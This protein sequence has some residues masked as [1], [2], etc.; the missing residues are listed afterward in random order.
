MTAVVLAWCGLATTT[1]ASESTTY[2]F[3][4]SFAQ[5]EIQNTRESTSYRFLES[6][7]EGSDFTL[8]E[9]PSNNEGSSESGDG[10]STTGNG[11][12]GGHRGHGTLAQQPQEVGANSSE[13]TQQSTHS[14]AP[15]APPTIVTAQK[16]PQLPADV[17]P[18]S[19]RITTYSIGA[20][21]TSGHTYSDYG[22]R[23]DDN[24][25]TV[26]PS[27]DGQSFDIRMS[28]EATVSIVSIAVVAAIV[29]MLVWM[30]SLT[31]L[32]IFSTG[33]VLTWG[34]F[35][36]DK[37]HNKSGRRKK[38]HILTCFV[39][40]TL[41]SS[42]F[43]S[44]VSSVF[45]AT[46]APLRHAYSGRLLD[47][48]SIAITTD[49]TFRFSY[50]KSADSQAG[51]VTGTGAIN[52]SATNYGGWYETQ[53]VTPNSQGYVLLELGNST[54]LPAMDSF[55]VSTLTSLYLQVEVKTSSAADT[56]YE[57]L[58][59]NASSS[60]IDRSS[61]LSV[62]LAL[63]ADMLDQRDVGTGS[64]SIPVLQAGGVLSKAAIAGGTNSGSFVIDA[65]ESE[66][67]S[68]ILQ[69][70]TSLT[71]RLTFD[72]TNDR[73]SF[74]KGISVHGALSGSTLRI[75][76][77][78]DI[79]GSLASSGSVTTR[80][81]LSGAIVRSFGLTDCDSA[82]TSKLLWDTT[83]GKFSCGYDT[84]QP[85]SGTGALQ[86]T[87]DTRYVKQQ[88]GTMTG[89]LVINLSS[90]TTGL[91][92]KQALSGSI[93]HA[94]GQL[95]SSGSLVV[96]GATTLKST[97]NVTGNT[98]MDGTSTFNGTLTFGDALTDA[99]TIYAAT[100]TFQND[101]NFALSGGVNGLSFDTSTLSIDAQNDRVGI[102]T[103]APDATLEIAGTMSGQSL[104]VGGGTA[105]TKI[106]ST[107]ATLDF[108]L[109]LSTTCS[110]LTMT[111]TGAETGD[112]A[113]VTVDS[114]IA[115]VN[116]LFNAWVS[117]ANTVSVRYCAIGASINVSS[118]TYRV[119]VFKH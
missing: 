37:L 96:N 78:A 35:K 86:T 83:T 115:P 47:S 29:V 48:N 51:D 71:R 8:I 17:H 104:V 53:T 118:G 18:R 77:N 36:S 1:H 52:T 4:E 102:G 23:V 42:S 32:S 24:I 62:P 58:D 39:L 14:A 2:K 10:A 88:G 79:W 66:S 41:V 20:Q 26:H 119:Q 6:Q 68:V 7:A 28:P 113:T 13:T 40:L 45:A 33:V 106:L 89:A 76:G 73:F 69:F 100:W 97:L 59:T 61:I 38:K 101:T 56:T 91:S 27:A 117:A 60:T 92:V 103:T 108:P 54:A 65:D 112:A 111:V 63:N 55:A 3:E 21:D 107:T 80:G 110:D 70:G 116:G 95:R 16:T 12:G 81:T 114:L 25:T 109:L 99:I 87:F 64:G 57:L 98:T 67:A 19:Q 46:T 93:I 75:D 15:V 22:T 9:E 84:N 34:Y 94:D 43:L 105:I 44:S 90:G 11:G 72:I 82:T 30:R 31:A 5:D 49:H 85:W 50:W 74:S